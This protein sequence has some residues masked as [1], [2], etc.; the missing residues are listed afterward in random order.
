L[1]DPSDGDTKPFWT[2][3]GE[4]VEGS[5]MKLWKV[6]KHLK[7]EVSP[8]YLVL[9]CLSSKKDDVYGSSIRFVLATDK[10]EK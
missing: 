5:S 10:I 7:I 9:I 6:I 3:I 2:K 8:L 4:N 1:E